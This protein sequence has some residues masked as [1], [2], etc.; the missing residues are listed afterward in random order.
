MSLRGN[1]VF[2][3]AAALCACASPQQR[4]NSAAMSGDTAQLEALLS[5][6]VSP[7]FTLPSDGKGCS[8]AEA[9]SPLQ[10][11]AC[12][13]ENDAVKLLLKHR[14]AVDMRLSDRGTALTLAAKH[15]HE[16][17]VETLLDAGADPNVADVAGMTPLMLAAGRAD[18]V[19]MLIAHKADV[20][21]VSH[22][23]RNALMLTTSENVAK[24]LLD[25]G[26]AIDAKDYAG[27]T[28][29]LH[30]VEADAPEVIE[31]LL[32]RG[33]D[34]TIRDSRGETALQLAVREGESSALAA[35]RPVAEKSIQA[36]ISQAAR[37]AAAGRVDDAVASYEEALDRSRAFPERAAAVRLELIRFV[38]RLPRP[39][40]MPAEARR[41]VVQGQYLLKQGAS[42]SEAEAEM[43]Q[44][45]ALAPWWADGYYNL[46]LLQAG[47][48][49]YDD[50]V[51]NL[52]LFLTAAPSSPRA[53]AAQDKIYEFEMAKKQADKIRALAG[54]W[55]DASGTAYA[56]SVDGGN[57]RAAGANGVTLTATLRN[58]RIEGSVESQAAQGDDACT[59]P[60]QI[61]PAAGRVD[62]DGGVIEFDYVWSSYETHGHPEFN[63]KPWPL[64]CLLCTTV[65]DA[66]NV[67]ATNN[68]HARLV[69]R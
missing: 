26:A 2:V 1:G 46:G 63:G 64:N 19:E 35:L 53:Q 52:R 11:A 3:V 54:D 59:I 13:G 15:G 66:V 55:T 42:P 18:I 50:A 36:A 5:K 27:D 57:L 6:G 61:H 56:V 37:Q 69:H 16:A 45:V 60:G 40:A 43:A 32:A 48:N 31:F 21:A 4:I 9:L 44:A 67:V 47:E 33:A 20:S 29:L 23:G 12:G 14:A 28:A 38:G 17:V 62:L 22:E 30:A 68:V 8:E 10:A 65:C 25:R 34:A 39:P 41:H 51:A 58:S 49:H 24:L 7:D